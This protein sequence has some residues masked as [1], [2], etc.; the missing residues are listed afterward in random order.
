MIVYI[1]D[2]Y[3]NPQQQSVVLPVRTTPLSVQTPQ[4]SGN[5]G[6]PITQVIQNPNVQVAPGGTVAATSSGVVVT[7]IGSPHPQA[8][9]QTHPT[10]G[11]IQTVKIGGQTQQVQSSYV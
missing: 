3:R 10:A 11:T 4:S 7:S 5:A 1:I 8:A 6:F 2:I 9:M